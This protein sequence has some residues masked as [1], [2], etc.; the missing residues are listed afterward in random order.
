MWN[1]HTVGQ[2][3]KKEKKKKRENCSLGKRARGRERERGYNND[4]GKIVFLSVSLAAA[5]FIWI[6]MASG[7]LA[8]A[9]SPSL[10][11]I[12]PLL[13]K[14]NILKAFNSPAV[15]GANLYSK[16]KGGGGSRARVFLKNIFA[17]ALINDIHTH[18]L[19][20]FFS[21]HTVS[22]CD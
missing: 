16:K 12:P 4:L 1:T 19:L 7:V 13:L 11:I 2:M 15:C 17:P 21:T 22:Y 3:K 20:S 8:P 5:T 9:K 6:F 18:I 14:D 10:V